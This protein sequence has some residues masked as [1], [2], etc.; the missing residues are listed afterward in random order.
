MASPTQV[1]VGFHA[2]TA[3]LRSQ[4]ESV[5]EL[6]L[7]AT[8]DDARIRDLEAYAGAR[9]A[10]VM[11][12]ATER[13]DGLAGGA[14]HQGAVARV[15]VIAP[16]WGSFEDRLDAVSGAPLVVL[17]DGVTDPHNLGAILRTCDAAGVHAV[18]APKDRTV[19]LSSTV[20]KVASGAAETV[21]FFMVPNLARVMGD[22]QERGLWIVGLA[23]EGGG[24]LYDQQ[25]PEAV[26]FALGA[27]GDGLRRLTR[28]R[29]DALVR[30]PMAGAI[31]S[32]NVSVAA[33]V[34]LFE[35]VRRRGEIERQRQIA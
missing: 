24:E 31:E 26:A 23:E 11:K 14:R 15:S 28:E 9:G 34:C 6:Y 33:G 20:M 2:I 1:I 17:L 13:L 30:I 21:P 27:E 3:R 12:V 29:C 8:R 7:D 35:A 18:I 5:A 19:G 16:R 4:P 32:L 25:W 10:R 22:L